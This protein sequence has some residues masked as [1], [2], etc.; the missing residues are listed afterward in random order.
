M[1]D[2]NDKKDI[3]NDIFMDDPKLL[4]AYLRLQKENSLEINPKN[5]DTIKIN[6]K[7]NINPP[8]FFSLEEPNKQQTTNIGLETQQNKTDTKNDNIK[9][10]IKVKKRKF[11]T[12]IN[13]LVFYIAIFLLFILIFSMITNY[14]T[15][16]KQILGYSFFVVMTPSM[17]DVY[18]VGTLVVVKKTDAEKI[19]VGD[20]I[21][22]FVDQ[23]TTTV[24][25]RVELIYE[26][27]KNTDKRAFQTKGTNINQV[28][29][30]AVPASNV[31]GVVQTSLKGV[32]NLLSYFSQYFWIYLIFFIALIVFVLLIRYY[33]K[34]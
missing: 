12:I 11:I 5:K 16:N 1:L 25:H 27:Y 17:E 13:N 24:T 32:G 20:D 18:P 29:P 26:N 19:K 31:V 10:R 2:D 28:D 8:I 3:I 15:R 22:F 4:S 14:N 33:R 7:E 6:E 34:K 23:E 21:T 30:G 9:T